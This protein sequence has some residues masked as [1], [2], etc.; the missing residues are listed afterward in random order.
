MPA[1]AG[2]SISGV[3]WFGNC[4]RGTLPKEVSLPQVASTWVCSLCRLRLQFSSSAVVALGSQP[5]R[6]SGGV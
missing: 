1:A 3:P 5:V 2:L 4:F 6:V